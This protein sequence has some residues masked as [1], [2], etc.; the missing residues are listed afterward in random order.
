MN[1]NKAE[2]LFEPESKLL[3]S[4]YLSSKTLEAVDELLFLVKK[5]LPVEKRRKLTKSIFY[6]TCLKVI[7][8]DDYSKGKESNFVKKIQK[9][10]QD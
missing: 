9:L 4:F 3:V 10:M 1:D 8:E 6:E 5:Q 7:I 2:N